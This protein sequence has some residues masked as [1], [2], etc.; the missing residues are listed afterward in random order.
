MNI[1]Q[2]SRINMPQISSLNNLNTSENFL[3]I[4]YE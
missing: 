3:F 4:V 1:S 2:M